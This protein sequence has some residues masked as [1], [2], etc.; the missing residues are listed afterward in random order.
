LRLLLFSAKNPFPFTGEIVMKI[1]L[2]SLLLVA[3][4]VTCC[5]AQSVTA[6]CGA[7]NVSF[8]VKLD[9]TQHTPAPPLPG[10][11]LVYFIHDAGSD[12]V[13]AYPTTKFAMDGAWVGADHSNS[14]FAVPVEPGE[15]HL[16]ATLQSSLVDD[17]SEFAHFTAEPGKVYFFRTRLVLSRAVELLEL[18]P[19]DSDQGRYL[20]AIYPL[21]VS[22]PKK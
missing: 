6:S 3:S 15:H 11:A 10:K 16:C 4:A 19:I 12:A 14:Y 20:V 9:D 18:E 2:L 21:A 7:G 5:P 22:T 17:R 8:K 13:L 1:A